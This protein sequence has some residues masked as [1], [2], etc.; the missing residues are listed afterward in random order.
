MN[1]TV[2]NGKKRKDGSLGIGMGGMD[3]GEEG[4]GPSTPMS[5]ERRQG[6]KSGVNGAGPSGS[7]SGGGPGA[8]GGRG[9]GTEIDHDLNVLHSLHPSLQWTEGADATPRLYVDD[10]FFQSPRSIPSDAATAIESGAQHSL[11]LHG[12]PLELV[13]AML[14]TAYAKTYGQAGRSEVVYEPTDW[15]ALLDPSMRTQLQDMGY[16]H[17]T[18][19]STFHRGGDDRH[20]IF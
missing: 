4:S 15:D 9:K 17:F 10:P 19:G 2:R 1:D 13:S 14:R 6:R 5:G 8:R 11:K 12:R 7:A 3:M 20:T 16:V 18:F